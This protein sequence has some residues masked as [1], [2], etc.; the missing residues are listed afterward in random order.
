MAKLEGLTSGGLLTRTVR[1]TFAG[2]GDHLD[3]GHNCR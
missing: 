3:A 1:P 2:G